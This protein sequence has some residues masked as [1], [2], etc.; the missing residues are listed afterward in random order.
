M[1]Q[2]QYDKERSE[3]LAVQRAMMLDPS[4]ASAWAQDE[5][6]DDVAQY[7]APQSDTIRGEVIA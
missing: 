3:Y 5:L 7:F 2:E 6:G 4:L 1:T